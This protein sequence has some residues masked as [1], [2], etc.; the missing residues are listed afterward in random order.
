MI[1]GDVVE[2]NAQLDLVEP[3]V[4]AAVAA[5]PEEAYVSAQMQTFNGRYGNRRYTSMG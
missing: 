3:E 5:L 1:E 2:V 4:V